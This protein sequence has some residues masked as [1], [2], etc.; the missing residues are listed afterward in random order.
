MNTQTP[1]TT[2]SNPITPEIIA[3]CRRAHACRAG[4]EYL[5]ASPRTVADLYAHERYWAQWLA[6]NVAALP[7]AARAELYRLT[8]ARAWWRDGVR[9]REDGP[10]IESAGGRREWYRAGKLHRD[11]GPAVES[12]DGYRE[13]WRDGVQLPAPDATV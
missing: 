12:A 2:P 4:L 7:E 6:L 11:D 13:W 8:G 9:H 3:G 1:E 10:A 5:E